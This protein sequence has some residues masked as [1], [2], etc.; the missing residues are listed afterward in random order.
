[1]DFTSKN[2]FASR[3]GLV[4]IFKTLILDEEV[5][6]PGH[7]VQFGVPQEEPHLSFSTILHNAV[8]KFFYTTI[9]DYVPE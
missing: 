1:M 9:L 2:E 6:C 3:P 5:D 8:W 4:H 7:M